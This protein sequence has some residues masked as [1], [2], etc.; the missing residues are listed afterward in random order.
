M[1][2]P[3]SKRG[4]PWVPSWPPWSAGPGPSPS[5]P[6]WRVRLRSA[7]DSDLPRCFHSC[8]ASATCLRFNNSAGRR[9]ITSRLEPHVALDPCPSSA[10]LPAEDQLAP[11]LI[12]GHPLKGFLFGRRRGDMLSAAS[13]AGRGWTI[14]SEDLFLTAK[15]FL[16]GPVV[17]RAFS[18]PLSAK[19]AQTSPP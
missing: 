19:Q 15:E 11:P 12:D 5:G 7:D 6:G 8:R 4:I 13:L 17:N 2:K 1:G 10:R 9:W 18:L 3:S 14:A 16:C